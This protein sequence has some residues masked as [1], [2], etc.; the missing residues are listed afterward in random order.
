MD[1]DRCVQDGG[2]C[3]L[4]VYRGRRCGQLRVTTKHGELCVQNVEVEDDGGNC[5]KKS[6]FRSGQENARTFGQAV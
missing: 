4:T 2:V 1:D 6:N 5:S 3:L